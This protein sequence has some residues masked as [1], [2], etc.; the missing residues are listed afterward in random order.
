MTKHTILSNRL[1]YYIKRIN[2][3]H[4]TQ[5][6]KRKKNK[7]NYSNTFTRKQR[8]NNIEILLLLHLFTTSTHTYLEKNKKIVNIWTQ[9]IS[10]KLS[11]GKICENI[12]SMQRCQFQWKMSSTQTIFIRFIVFQLFLIVFCHPSSQQTDFIW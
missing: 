12:R 10:E 11:Q 9:Y 2:T 8:I 3:L 7:R 1:Y 4:I 6:N 5:D